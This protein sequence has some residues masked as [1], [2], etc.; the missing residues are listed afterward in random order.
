[1]TNCIIKINPYKSAAKYAAVTGIM[2]ALA[3]GLTALES[4]FSAFLPVGMRIGLSNIVIMAVCEAVNPPTAFVITV[5]KAVFVLATRGV[6]AGGMSLCGGIF[7]FA[8][9]SV[10]FTR[11]KASYMLISAAAAVLHSVGQLVLAAVIMKSALAFYYAPLLLAV[12]CGSGICTGI[13]LGAI[14]PRLKCTWLDK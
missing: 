10:L 8:V 13:A 11:T 12:S 9:T 1:M 2:L 7:A 6:T 4:V 3:C 5:L 14:M